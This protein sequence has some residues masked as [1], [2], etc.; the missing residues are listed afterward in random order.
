MTME[1]K[2]PKSLNIEIANGAKQIIAEMLK[3][4]ILGFEQKLDFKELAEK[5]AST[6]HEADVSACDEKTQTLYQNLFIATF[7]QIQQH[8]KPLMTAL[9]MMNEQTNDPQTGGKFLGTFVLPVAK[10]I[11]KQLD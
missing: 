7:T 10:S 9:H 8:S 4:L 3:A 6:T 5:H 2:D 1:S 11:A